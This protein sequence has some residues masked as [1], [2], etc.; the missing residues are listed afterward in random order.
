PTPRSALTWLQRAH[1]ETTFSH[2]WAPPRLRGTTWSRLV[3]GALQYWHRPPSRA[4]TARRVSGTVAAEGTL[5]YR[6]SFTTTGTGTARCSLWSV[7]SP[8]WTATALSVRS[9]T[10]ARR[11]GTTH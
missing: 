8:S 5:T 2:V 7:S 4:K 1:A 3:D 10:T 11:P 6:V 9:S